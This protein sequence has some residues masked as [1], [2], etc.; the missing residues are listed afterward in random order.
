MAI[1]NPYLTFNGNCEEAFNFY[2]R[3][4]GGEF[5]YLGRFNEMPPSEEGEEIP[6]SE[7]NKIMHISLPMSKETS[8]MGSDSSDVYGQATVIGN[9]F[10]ISINAESKEEADRLYKEL[11]DGGKQTM[12]M[13]TTFWGSYFGMLTDRFS[14]QWMISYDARSANN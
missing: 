6:E 7:A 2:K 4:F 10:S 13:N 5:S 14:V 8:L 3:V 9:N 12:P 11:S 1:I